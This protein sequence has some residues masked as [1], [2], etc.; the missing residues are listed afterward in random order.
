MDKRLVN[1]LI[2]VGVFCGLFALAATFEEPLRDWTRFRGVGINTGATD[3]YDTNYPLYVVGTIWAT[4]F[5]G[6]FSD[7]TFSGTVTLGGTDNITFTGNLKLGSIED[8]LYLQNTE[9]NERSVLRVLPKG[10]VASTASGLEIFGTDYIADTVNYE[11]LTLYGDTTSYRLFTGTG[12]TGTVRPLILGTGANTSQ[13]VCNIDGN[14]GI[15]T[16]TPPSLL[17]VVGGDSLFGGLRINGLDGAVNQI[18]QSNAGTVLGITGSD[19]GLSLGGRASA[20]DLLIANTGA[21]TIAET[22]TTT[23]NI[24]SEPK[25]LRFNVA[26]PNTMQTADGEWCLVPAIDAAITVTRIVVTLDAA[27]NEVAGDLKYADTFIG[28]ANATVINT[29]DTTSGVL[30][31]ST[32]TVGA[33][34]AGKCIYISFDSAP[35]AAITQMCVDVYYDYD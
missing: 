30:D 10:T 31:D 29:F 7:P 15:G 26:N 23:A 28:L 16:A 32:I 19:S 27:G 12:G 33:V 34:A 17:T 5:E 14:V 8:T 18:Y 35:N 1:I 6:T 2:G 22:L 20:Q 9:P 3:T 21:V 24:K 25:H 4:A 11:R 13:L